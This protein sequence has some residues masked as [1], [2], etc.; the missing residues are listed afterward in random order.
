[1]HIHTC[2]PKKNTSLF[3]L[4][5][6]TYLFTYEGRTVTLVL[7]SFYMACNVIEENISPYYI[8]VVG[9]PPLVRCT[10]PNTKE[11]HVHIC[12]TFIDRTCIEVKGHYSH[13]L[14]LQYHRG[15]KG[16]VDPPEVDSHA[17]GTCVC[18]VTV[19][20]YS[21]NS[22]PSALSFTYESNDT[23]TNLKKIFPIL[24][25]VCQTATF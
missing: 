20:I 11:G 16:Q 17:N 25:Q 6:R 3:I 1:M 13:I 12:I 9:T 15:R 24:F 2:S 8:L 4:R 19:F 21:G 10:T 22:S 14:T 7:W 5:V 23:K 18:N